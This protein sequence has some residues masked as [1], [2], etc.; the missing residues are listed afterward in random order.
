MERKTGRI[1]EL[2]WGGG[3]T[4]ERTAKQHRLEK[5]EEG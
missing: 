4:E 1:E 3:K 2:G 5:Q